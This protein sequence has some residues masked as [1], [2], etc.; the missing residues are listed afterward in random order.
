MKRSKLKSSPR[1]PSSPEPERLQDLAAIQKLMADA[2]MRPLDDD[3]RMKK[4]WADGVATKDVANT[5]IKPNDRLSSFERLEI[6]NRQYWFR[7]LDC[8]YEDYPGLRVVLGES[9]FNNLA[10]AYLSATPSESFTLRN[11]GARLIPF[12]EA[13]S[14]W[15]KPHQKMAI[16]MARLEWAQIEAFDIRSQ[17]ASSLKHLAGKA[18]SK[19]YLQL[20]PYITLLKLSYPVDE[21]LLRILKD[22]DMLRSEASNAVE[23]DTGPA[24][25]SVAARIRPKATHLIIHRVDNSVFFKKL[26]LIQYRLLHALQSG[27]NLEDACETAFKGVKATA[28]HA[29]KLQDWF[30]TWT[31]LGWFCLVK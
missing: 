17:R 5:F 11:L 10:E 1:N 28:S 25:K 23:L 26:T 18:P 19:I 16:D 20:Q 8:F 14:K 2:I 22:D 13:E 30:A 9:K 4:R 27:E 12:L 3:S 24:V 31:S 7:I 15:T 29:T 6:Y 21:I